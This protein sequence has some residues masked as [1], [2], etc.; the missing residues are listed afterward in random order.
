MMMSVIF[1]QSLE[2]KK[3]GFNS[4]ANFNKLKTK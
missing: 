4:F 3:T 1:F 2:R